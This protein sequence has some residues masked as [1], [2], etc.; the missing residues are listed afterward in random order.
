MGVNWCLID[1]DRKYAIV[2]EPDKPD[3]ESLV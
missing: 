2:S 1:T 3:V